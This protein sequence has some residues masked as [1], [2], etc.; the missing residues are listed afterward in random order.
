MYRPE[1]SGNVAS[2]P[3]TGPY[4][5]CLQ[6]CGIEKLGCQPKRRDKPRKTARTS[7]IE[8]RRARDKNGK[9]DDSSCEEPER[10][11]D[12]EQRRERDLTM[13]EAGERKKK[14]KSHQ[15]GP[16][17][18]QQKAGHHSEH[19]SRPTKFHNLDQYAQRRHLREGRR[20]R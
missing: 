6:K 18:S 16:A 7:T 8:L 2:C 5:E 12:D 13:A 3:R 9:V 15:P 10:E 14:K 20:L 11:H 19:V 4:D 1:P 17:V